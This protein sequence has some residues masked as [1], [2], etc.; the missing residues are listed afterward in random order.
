MESGNRCWVLTMGSGPRD[1]HTSIRWIQIHSSI[2]SYPERIHPPPLSI[3]HASDSHQLPTLPTLGHPPAKAS[4]FSHLWMSNQL[5]SRDPLL[6]SPDGN[7]IVSGSR[8]KTIRVWNATT[9]QCV[10]GPFQGHTGVV[11]FVAYSPDGN[12]IV[13]RSDDQSIKV[14]NTEAL[15][16]AGDFSQEHGWILSSNNSCYG[17][18]SPQ[19]LSAFHLPVHSLIISSNNTYQPS[20]DFSLFG[21]SWISCWR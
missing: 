3:S 4:F 13:S 9:G 1:C 11:T 16:L 21:E 8:D 7:Q 14:W 15:L 12:Q 10:A 17:W 2:C 6:T 19:S 20:I 5:A 18:F